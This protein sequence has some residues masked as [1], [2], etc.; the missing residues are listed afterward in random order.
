MHIKSHLPFPPYRLLFLVFLTTIWQI[1]AQNRPAFSSEVLK[2]MH[3]R[4][5]GPG[6][7][8]GRITAIAVDPT[9]PEVIYAGAASGGVWRSKS[10]GTAWEPIF[11]KAPT[12]GIGSIAINPRNPDEIWVG[13]GE[14]NPRNSQNFGIGIFKTINGGKDWTCMGLQNTHTIHRVLLHR[15]NPDIVF[16]ASLGS[17][18][19]PTEERGVF[20]STDGG[21]TWKKTLFVNN[22]TGCADLVADPQN[23]NKLFAAMW[24][25]QRWPWFFKSG[26]KGSGLYV[27][28]DAGETWEKRTSKDGLPEGDLGRLGLAVAKSNPDIVYALVEAKENALYK[29]TDGGLKWQK[30][31]EKGQGDRPF[32]YSEIY[33]DP[34]NENR[35]YSIYTY[36]SKSEDGGK[37]FSTWAGWTIHPDHHAFWISPDNPNYIIN[38]NDGGLNIT[39]DGG[40]TWRY[41]ENIPVGQFY[42]VETDNEWPY[43]VYGGLQDNGSWVG[44]SAVWKSGGI[45]NSDWQEVYFGDGFE[46]MP[47]KDDPRYVFAQS[48]GGELGLIDRKTGEN[49]YLKPL[50]PDGETYLRFN[51]NTALAQDPHRAH[52]IYF[53]SQFV[54]YSTDLGQNWQIISP[55]LTTND[56][57]KM[58]QDISGGLTFD[59]TNAENHCTI[60]AINPS[61]VQ[62]GVVWVGTD[63][64]NVQLTQDGGKN[65]SNFGDKLPDAP[66]NGWIPAI[67]ASPINAGEAFVVLNNY[68]L[69]D[70]QPYLYHTQDFGKKWKRL[71]SPK[72]L[73]VPNGANGG[74]YCL[75]VVQD[76][77]V[78][79]LIFLGTEHGLFVSINYGENWVQF[80]SETLPAVPIFDMKIQQ[81]D[82]DLVLGTFGR[83]IWILDNLA[84]L[85]ELARSGV[86]ILDQPFKLFPA[87]PGI[88]A[89][90]RSFDGPRF[91]VDATYEGENKGTGVS[92][93]VWVKPGIKKAG[94]GKGE[95]EIEEEDPAGKSGSDKATT[96]KPASAKATAGK[97]AAGKLTLG[98][99]PPDKSASGKDSADK[100]ADKATSASAKATAGKDE[101]PSA[102][103]TAG[104]KAT[105][106]VLSLEGD[107]L[108]RFKTEL[109]S[110]F[111]SRIW[112]NMDTKGARFPSKNE[113]GP[114][115][116][117]PWGGPQVLPGEYWVK[118]EYMGYQDS[119]KVKVMDDPRLN[120]ARADREAQIAA[121][122]DMHQVVERSTKAYDRLKEAEKTI[123]LVESQMVNVPDSLKKELNKM[124]SALKDSISNLKEQFFQHKEVKGIQRNPDVLVA[125]M[126]KALGYIGGGQGAPN[127]NAQIAIR[128]AK[129]EAETLIDSVNQLIEIQW[130]AYREQ[131]ESVR[132]TLF[133]DFE[134]I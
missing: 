92:I 114:D 85:R 16:A 26:G 84:P 123:G 107:T 56:T 104:K 30:M 80:P 24:E 45:R 41:A 27:S 134:R 109:D 31:A 44:P 132:F 49:K 115:Q 77:E 102:K 74:N 86:A 75:S 99:N 93:P 82:G 78:E 43:N 35:V 59:A 65:W 72:N 76:T 119:V 7:M 79:N 51:W 120:I 9:H 110:A 69:N 112:W 5:I 128:N 106:M 127:A 20:K 8:S 130:K 96:D 129:Q 4:N 53:G 34:K 113:P 125:K 22:L 116:L 62:Q 28:Y 124:G 52:G 111:L 101:K 121:I 12:Q 73:P 48:Q 100:S 68:R 133:K 10:G 122:R 71:A 97:D 67:E 25:Y 54:H 33:V 117:E 11:D 36:I 1:N 23:P 3:I 6:A 13:T 39:M 87:Q 66:K 57:S 38:G 88:L 15:D 95:D 94:K 83:G 32:Y 108:R 70:W 18:Y 63:D 50:H 40:K 126:R 55:D 14:G 19:G 103:A 81:R 2:T 64:G 46:T 21:K 29:S 91:A 42:H 89:E 61:P 60:I 90:F 47:R 118:A 131:V 98:K 105:I 37:T 58:H 17:T